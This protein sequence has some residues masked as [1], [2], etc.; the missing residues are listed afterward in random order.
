MS[1]YPLWALVCAILGCFGAVILLAWNTAQ[2][3]RA[4]RFDSL[5]A[6][7]ARSQSLALFRAVAI[8]RWT[9]IGVLAIAVVGL[10]RLVALGAV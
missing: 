4:G 10:I 8:A 5:I 9:C 6:V 7:V 2:E 1:A 3:Q